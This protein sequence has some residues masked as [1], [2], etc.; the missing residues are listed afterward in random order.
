M[1]LLKFSELH[2]MTN[3][4]SSINGSSKK[5]EIYL[6]KDKTLN[7]W[8]AVFRILIDNSIID[9]MLITQMRS[10]NPKTFNVLEDCL[11]QMIS[12]CVGLGVTGQLKLELNENI[13]ELKL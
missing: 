10:N 12:S 11:N 9:E 2:L 8:K 13:W 5:Y 3:T 7:K 6:S 4:I 1:K